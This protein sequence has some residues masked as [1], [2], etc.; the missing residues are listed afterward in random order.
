MQFKNE[1]TCTDAESHGS[2]PDA[3]SGMMVTAHVTDN[4]SDTMVLLD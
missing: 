4:S 2:P 1:T 3:S